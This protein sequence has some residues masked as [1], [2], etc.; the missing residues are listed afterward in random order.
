M[1]FWRLLDRVWLA[2]GSVK[3]TLLIFLGLLLLSVPG[4]VILQENM[5]TVDPGL[6]YD[7]EFWQW[8]QIMQLFRSYHSFWYVGLLVLLSINLVICSYERWPQMWKLAFAK[9]VALADATV[10]KREE[11][12]RFSWES[13]SKLSQVQENLKSWAQKKWIRYV[14][15]EDN[16]SNKKADEA[17]R[18]QMTWQK[19]KFSRLANYLVHTSLLMIFA[20]AI[21][22]GLYGFEGVMNI[23]EGSAVDTFLMFKEGGLAALERPPQNKGLPNERM[24]DF[25]LEA[26]RF[27]VEFYKDFPGRPKEFTTQLN[28]IERQTGQV[29]QSKTIEVNDPLEYGKFTFYQASY[30]PLGDYSLSLR[31]I[32]KSSLNGRDENATFDDQSFVKTQLGKSQSVSFTNGKVV[33]FVPLRFVE[34][35]QGRGPALQVQE[36]QGDALVGEAF[37][38][39]KKD[40][41]YDFGR[42]SDWALVVDDYK[43]LYYTGLQVGYDPG[44]PIY[45]L[46]C[47]GM[48]LGTF[49]ALFFQH[50]KYHF[51]VEETAQGVRLLFTGA[52]HRL[53]FTF[54]TELKKIKEELQEL[55][56]PLE[57]KGA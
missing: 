15:V 31:A 38:V 55:F 40:P 44:A 23:P 24:L 41:V 4:T 19:H 46:G 45:W 34:D 48:L 17:R 51:I 43:A 53:P 7:F 37:W 28:V 21:F 12:Y 6:Q 25:R 52:T 50:K 10:L 57:A 20:G 54:E 22:S 2:L 5:S 39:L 18:W 11:A 42:E 47:L 32:R 35:L 13:R 26:S 29:L 8:G 9:P 16:S 27:N 49:Y 3:V 30:G 1:Y 33:S 36:S 56:P 14:V